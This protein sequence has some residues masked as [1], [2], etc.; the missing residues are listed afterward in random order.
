MGQALFMPS[1]LSLLG[2]SYPDER[3]RAR[4]FGLWAALVSAASGLGPFIGGVLVELAGW[5]SIFLINVP[6]G[7]AALISAYR[8]LSRVPGKSDRVNI[9]GHLLGMMALGFLSYALI[10]GPSAGWRSPVILAA[11][12]LQRFWHLCCFYCGKFL[13]KHPSCRRPYTKTAASQLA[14]FIGFLLNFALFGGMFML[15]LFLQEAGGAS[16]FMAGVELPPMMAVFVIG[17]LLFARLANR[18]E[19]GQLMFVSMAVSCIIALLLFVLISPDFPYWRLAVLMSVM[20]LCTGVTVPAMTTVIMQVAGQRHA[21]I[22]GAALN[23]NRQIGALVGVA[24]TGVIIH[25]SAT[26]YAGAGFTFL[27]M[28]AAYSLGALLVWLF[29]VKLITELPR[30]K[31][32]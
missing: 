29:L 1:S 22:A 14:Q 8:I 20:N 12:T 28:G 3:V 4:M 15:S 5:Q 13:Q 24:I 11:F 19:A 31:K 6:I 25:L 18:F 7:A 16:S 32:M 23:A 30:Q 2:A 26:W 21:N 17:N 27:M 9:I 10:Q